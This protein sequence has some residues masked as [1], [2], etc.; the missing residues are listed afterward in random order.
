MERK[1]GYDFYKETGALEPFSSTSFKP[2][3]IPLFSP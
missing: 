2:H 3:H 1:E